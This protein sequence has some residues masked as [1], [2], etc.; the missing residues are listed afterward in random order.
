[1][2][3]CWQFS[4]LVLSYIS[5][6]KAKAERGIYSP[7]CPFNSDFRVQRDLIHKIE[8]TVECLNH[9]KRETFDWVVTTYISRHSAMWNVIYPFW[10]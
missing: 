6:V 2:Y 10:T 4:S 8:D 9:I 5:K 7:Q 1:M 3:C